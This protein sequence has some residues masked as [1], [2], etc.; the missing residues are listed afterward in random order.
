MSVTRLARHT[1]PL[2]VKSVACAD[3]RAARE[4]W[5]PVRLRR[6]ERADEDDESVPHRVLWRL[7]AALGVCLVWVLSIFWALKQ[8][9]QQPP[10]AGAGVSTVLRVEGQVGVRP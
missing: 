7:A 1:T 10:C 6:L 9:L 3:C 8:Q 4:R 2:H 5:L